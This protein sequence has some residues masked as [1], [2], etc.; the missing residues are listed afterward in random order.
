M[1]R[2]T[3]HIAQTKHYP[4]IFLLGKLKTFSYK[5]LIIIR[6]EIFTF[7]VW[8][9]VSLIDFRIRFSWELILTPRQVRDCGR[10]K[11]RLLRTL[12]NWIHVVYCLC[13][14]DGYGIV[15]NWIC[16]WFTSTS[17]NWSL[18][19]YCYSAM[20]WW[21]CVIP[22]TPLQICVSPTIEI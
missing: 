11:M 18:W 16:E 1:L 19:L 14:T 5:Q 15:C 21:V 10:L 6:I 7:Y 9:F 22:L 17:S 12:V 8:L 2:Y 4:P 13:G 20:G 3:I